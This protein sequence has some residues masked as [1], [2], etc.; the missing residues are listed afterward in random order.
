MDG[1]NR[2]PKPEVRNLGTIFNAGLTIISDVKSVCKLNY[3]TLTQLEKAIHAFFTSRLDGS[4][5][6]LYEITKVTLSQ[7][8]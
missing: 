1:I 6:P 5:S 3:T 8:Q 4:N 2:C 7:V